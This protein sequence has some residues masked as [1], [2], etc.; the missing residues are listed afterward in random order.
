MITSAD[1]FRQQFLDIQN[2]TSR[3]F[4]SLPSTEQRFIINANTRVINIPSEF[5]FLGV[6]NDHY[7]ETIYF[8]IDRYFDKTDLSK[9]TCVVQFVNGKSQG[10]YPVTAYDIETVEGKIIFGWEIGNDATQNYGDLEFSVRFYTVSGDKFTYNFNTTSSKSNILRGINVKD[11]TQVSITPSETQ[12]FINRIN[13]RE[14]ELAD[15]IELKKDEFTPKYHGDYDSDKQYGFLDIV[16]YPDNGC[17]YQNFGKNT[18]IGED[19]TASENW[20]IISN[21]DV[22][23]DKVSRQLAQKASKDELAVANARIT[24]IATLNEGSTTGDAELIDSRI[25]TEGFVYSNVGEA[26]RRQ[27][28][29]LNRL[30]YVDVPMIVQYTTLAQNGVYPF[31][32]NANN[33]SAIIPVSPNDEYL[34]DIQTYGGANYAYSYYYYDGTTYSLVGAYDKG[35]TGQYVNWSKKLIIPAG[36]NRLVLSWYKQSNINLK[37]KLSAANDVVNG[38][39][40]KIKQ[41]PEV[42]TRKFAQE[43]RLPLTDNWQYNTAFTPVIAGERYTIKTETFGALNYA[44]ILAYFDG[45]N[46]TTYQGCVLGTTGTHT[47]GEYDL[48]IPDGVNTLISSYYYTYEYEIYRCAP[49]SEYKLCAYEQMNVVPLIGLLENGLFPINSTTYPKNRTVVI[50]VQPGES[51]YLDTL[52]YGEKNYAYGLYNYNGSTYTVVNNYY[53]GTSAARTD[54]TYYITIPEHVNVLAYSYPAWLGKAAVIKKLLDNVNR[55]QKY[56]DNSV[57]SLKFA[58]FGDSITSDEKTGV[59]TLISEMLGTTLVGNFAHGNAKMQDWQSGG[60]NITPITFNIGVNTDTSENVLSNQIRSCLRYTTASGQ[61]VAWAHPIDGGFNI[62]TAIGTGLGNTDQIPDIA[63]IAMGIN[64][65]GTPTPVTDDTDTVFGQT[66]SQLTRISFASALRWAIE[67]LKSAYPN[68]VIFVASPLHTNEPYTR[69][70]YAN[71][72]LKRDI[73]AKVCMY[74]SVFFIDSFAECGFGKMEAVNRIYCIDGVHPDV[75]GKYNIARYVAKQIND[76]YVSKT[77]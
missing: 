1:E 31:I 32:S 30:K 20:E 44:Y 3:V 37:K 15:F 68:I 29:L 21:G 33:N 48:V 69:V 14:S 76:R 41:Y 49:K 72:K 18:P 16:Y 60:S 40:I 46:Y 54:G 27:F 57:K 66:Y 64:D 52:T 12:A 73:I 38:D 34:L 53:L 45:T 58:C 13:D 65:G 71:T 24:N 47:T 59:G 10:I 35:T 50:P 39:Q 7:A 26:I 55:V 17:S 70:N 23:L 36:V 5:G 25:S 11:S 51:Y 2:N 6:Q 42:Y 22:R 9:H 63:Y 62:D 56:A 4:T 75:A 77:F 28:E 74:E 67:T 43:G 8:E 19:P 61:Q